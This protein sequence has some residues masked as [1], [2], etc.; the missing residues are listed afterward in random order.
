MTPSKPQ[1]VRSAAKPRSRVK[2]RSTPPLPPD[3]AGCNGDSQRPT[4]PPGSTAE[5]RDVDF[6][7]H[8]TIP[9]PTWLG[10]GSEV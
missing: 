8:D 5:V 7:R 2:P 10:D 3:V 9:A 6:E 4:E 1:A